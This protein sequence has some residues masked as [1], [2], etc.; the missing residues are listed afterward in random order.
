[1]SAAPHSIESRHMNVCILGRLVKA[2]Q[3]RYSAGGLPHL[4]V[5]VRQAGDCVPFVACKHGTLEDTKALIELAA[6]LHSGTPV[7][8]LGA[9]LEVEPD[10]EEF[11]PKRSHVD[12]YRVRLVECK[13]IT[14]VAIADPAEALRI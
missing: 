5:C 10:V 1:M 13:Q 6:R 14:E 12:A 4:T 8:V 2:P 3:V 9:G 11:A 7:M